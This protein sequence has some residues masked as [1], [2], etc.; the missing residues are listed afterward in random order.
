MSIY[1]IK[2]LI[3]NNQYE[4]CFI[5]HNDA[6]F[7]FLD[8]EGYDKILEMFGKC[9]VHDWMYDSSTCTLVITV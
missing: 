8:V 2:T 5:I 4:T 3:T 1:S 7:P 9:P 6:I